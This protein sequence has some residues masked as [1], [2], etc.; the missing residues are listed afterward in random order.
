MKTTYIFGAI[1]ACS[2][3]GSLVGSRNTKTALLAV[4]GVLSAYGLFRILG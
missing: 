3:A 2:I 1:L 4:S